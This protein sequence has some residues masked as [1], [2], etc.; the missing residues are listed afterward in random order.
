MKNPPAGY[1]REGNTAMLRRAEENPLIR[2]ENI[3]ASGEGLRVVGT[4]NAGAASLGDETVLL[5]RV[6]EEAV[7]GAGA[8]A[9]PVFDEKRGRIVAARFDEKQVSREGDP[10]SFRVGGKQFLTS[11]SHFHVA[12]SRDGIHFTPDPEPFML[13]ANRY[14][15]FGIEDARITKLEGRYYITYTAASRL[16]CVVALAVTDDFVSAR[17]LGVLFPPDNKDTVYFD[18]KI[19]GKYYVLHRPS[20]SVFARPEMWLAESP[21][22]R[23]FGNHRFVAGVRPGMWD[24]DRIGAGAPPFL[25]E[26]GWVEIYH[27]VSG[28]G[29]YCMGAMLLDAEKPWRVLARSEKPLLEPE[30]PYE[31]T[32]FFGNVVFGCGAVRRGDVV[33]LYYGA[34]DSSVAEASMT[35]EDIY[36]NLNL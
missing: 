5:L 12:R 28:S 3:A 33:R 35:V 25:T 29:R 36:A 2:T 14:E 7:P 26:R 19:G 23:C 8:A 22:G 18:R 16:G 34:A 32:G 4:F 31:K 15:E 20:A 13:P 1:G 6:A 11:M 21:D 30:Y 10:R 9:C 27:G 17:R 24:S